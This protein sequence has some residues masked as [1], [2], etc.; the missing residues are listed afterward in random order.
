MS[1]GY[2]ISSVDINSVPSGTG[3]Q[4]LR[5]N[6]GNTALEFA[7][8][9]TT[10][11]DPNTAVLAQ[12]TT[13]T[14]YTTP[15]SAT[16]SSSS[17]SANTFSDD[18]ASYTTQTQA[19]TAWPNNSSSFQADITNDRQPFSTNAG[20][21]SARGVSHDLTSISNT[22]FLIRYKYVQTSYTN[23]STGGAYGMLFMQVS[24]LSHTDRTGNGSANSI[25]LGIYFNPTKW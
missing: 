23:Y 21:T 18:W 19:D 22:K 13:I 4:V 16:A 12:S 8:P 9:A 3:L 10:T 15:T 17:T 7:T 14:D 24:S 11:V 5:R 20:S 1:G 6:S 25:G 2:N